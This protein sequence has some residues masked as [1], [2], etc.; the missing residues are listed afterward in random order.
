M[1]G[2]AAENCPGPFRKPQQAWNS[3]NVEKSQKL[4]YCMPNRLKAVIA[5]KGLQTNY[6]ED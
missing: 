6:Y 3:I 4:V 5:A 2:K 1:Q